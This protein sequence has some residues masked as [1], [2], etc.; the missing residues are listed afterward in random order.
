MD[1]VPDFA[2]V[3]EPGPDAG[4]AKEMHSG[5]IDAALLELLEYQIRVIAAEGA[6]QA[7]AR[8]PHRCSKSAIQ[9]RT[10]RLTHARRP[11]RKHHVV[12]EQVT[13]Q[14]D[15]RDHRAGL[16]SVNAAARACTASRSIGLDQ[17]PPSLT[18]EPTMNP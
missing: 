14:D 18:D 8:V 15:R 7:G 12:D 9:Q 13:E 2:L 6:D 5:Q 11:I 16:S 3:E 17:T 10:T 1:Q 4:T